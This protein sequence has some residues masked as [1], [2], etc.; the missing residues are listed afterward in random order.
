MSFIVLLVIFSFKDGGVKVDY[1][2]K[3][4]C[5]QDLTFDWT[6]ETNTF[7]LQNLWTRDWLVI[8]DSYCFDIT[9]YGMLYLF[10]AGVFSGTS[11]FIALLLTSVTKGIVEDFMLTFD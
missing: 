7:T 9:M 4:V 2:A 8:F 6:N 3:G 10:W 11:T 5:M 1:L